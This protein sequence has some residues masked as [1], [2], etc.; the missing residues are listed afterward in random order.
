M[1]E[2][3]WE[4]KKEDSIGR[5]L[6][7]LLHFPKIYIL[8]TIYRYNNRIGGWSLSNVIPAGYSM[9]ALKSAFILLG[10]TCHIWIKVQALSLYDQ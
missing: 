3:T 9:Y 4:R 7:L 1:E 8:K 10:H 2:K 6:C 5:H